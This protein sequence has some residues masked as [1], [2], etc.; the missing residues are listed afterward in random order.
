VTSTLTASQRYLDSFPTPV[1]EFAIEGLD[2]LDVPLH[3][4]VLPPSPQHPGGSGLGYGATREEA[5][6]GA[7]GEMAEMALS[8]RAH[9][10]VQRVQASYAELVRR[11]GRDRVADPR[12]LCLEAGSAYDDDRPLQW[13]PMTRQRD[14]ETVLVPAELVASA[15]DDLPG[16]PPP[17][18]GCRAESLDPFTRVCNR[19]RT[20]RHRLTAA[21]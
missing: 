7:L 3:S 18:P 17:A 21:A 13:L 14:G 12:T 20:G 11:E 9:Q 5:R 1:D 2:V 6:T 4:A 10:G 16:A 8:L 19:F 15:P